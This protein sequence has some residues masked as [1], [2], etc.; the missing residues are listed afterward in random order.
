M[1]MIHQSE[2]ETLAVDIA[3]IYNLL[4]DTPGYYKPSNIEILIVLKD[5]DDGFGYRTISRACI[6]NP[7]EDIYDV[8]VDI[9]GQP[10]E[11]L[12]KLHEDLLDQLDQELP[13]EAKKRKFKY[14]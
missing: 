9:Q 4:Y 6:R 2:F 13:E 5:Y 11:A 3:S 10:L 1:K 12:H 8:V 14:N 7:E